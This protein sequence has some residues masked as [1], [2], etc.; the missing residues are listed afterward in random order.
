MD[1]L[2]IW[3]QKNGHKMDVEEPNASAW[4]TLKRNLSNQKEKD[5]LKQH[6]AENKNELE[7]ETPGAH[8]WEKISNSIK[9]KNPARAQHIQKRIFYY[10][11]A[12]TK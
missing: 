11:V 2:K 12:F 10:L 3:I 1:K 9:A 8:S 4:D 5:L 7:V 6:L